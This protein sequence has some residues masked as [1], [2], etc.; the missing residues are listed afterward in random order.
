MASE[1]NQKKKSLN[2][3]CIQMEEINFS[4]FLS[5]AGEMPKCARRA[6]AG[7]LSPREAEMKNEA[8]NKPWAFNLV[9]SHTGLPLGGTLPSSWRDPAILLVLCVCA[10][11]RACA[12]VPSQKRLDD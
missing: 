8:L 4:A 12:C 9:S 1:T 5:T 7:P 10:R 2:C 6:A 11:V 3:I